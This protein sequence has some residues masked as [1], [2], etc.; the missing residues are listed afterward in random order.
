MTNEDLCM[1]YCRVKM[2]EEQVCMLELKCEK[3]ER[4]NRMHAICILL[5]SVSTL[6]CSLSQLI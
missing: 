3:L 4:S 1:L 5:L 2:L 6:L